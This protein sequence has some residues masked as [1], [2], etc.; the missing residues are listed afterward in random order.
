M[1][2]VYNQSG[3]QNHSPSDLPFI[4]AHLLT[5]KPQEWLWKDFI[6]KGCIT[7]MAGQG[8]I[9]KSQFLLNLAAKVS[10][11]ESFE[12]GGEVHQIEQANCSKC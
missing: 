8:G 7:L 9:G 5:I 4:P 10:Q 3:K 6:P 12:A 2:T 11:G 1:F